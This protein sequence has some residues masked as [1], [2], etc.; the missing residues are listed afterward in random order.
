MAKRNRSNEKQPDYRYTLANERT[1][2][3]WIRTALAILATA[4]AV[5]QF[6]PSF[7]IPGGGQIIAILLTVSSIACVGGAAWRWNASQLAMSQ[8]AN[9]PSTLMPW[10]LAAAIMGIGLVVFLLTLILVT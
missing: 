8:D 4:I 1:F 7:S 5:A 3:A 6:A 10:L 9:L 2:L